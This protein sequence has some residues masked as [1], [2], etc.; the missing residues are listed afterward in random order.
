LLGFLA[1]AVFA[2]L[3]FAGG[4]PSDERLV[5]A[6]KIAGGI[7]LAEIAVLYYRS[8]PA[9]RLIVGA[10][11]WLVAGGFA[12]FT[13]QWWWLKGYQ[14]LGES[15]LFI[16]MLLVGLATSVFSAVGFAAVHGERRRVHIASVVLLAAVL[17]ALLASVRYRGTVQWA[18]VVPVI[19][20][21]W[22]NRL[23]RRS[24]SRGPD[25]SVKGTS[26]GKP[27]AAPYLER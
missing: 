16:S 21:S 27:Q 14:R 11:L 10:N 12:A 13:E 20:L 19:A 1:L 26:C 17:A 6:F 5:F 7:A 15:G 8:A 9:N 24:L 25:T 2:A 3:A 22:V 4:A 23:L 18:A